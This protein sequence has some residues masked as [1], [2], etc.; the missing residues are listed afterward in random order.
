[1]NSPGPLAAPAAEALQISE[2]VSREWGCTSGSTRPC[3]SQIYNEGAARGE[4]RG[5][6]AF[7]LANEMDALGIEFERQIVLLAR[8]NLR[9]TPPLTTAELRHA[10]KQASKSKY[11][12]YACG[13][14]YLSAYCIGEE[15]PHCKSINRWSKSPLSISNIIFSDWLPH[16]TAVQLKTFLGLYRWSRIIGRGPRHTV[17]FTFASIERVCGV[18]RK[19]IRKTLLAL[20]DYGLIQDVTFAKGKG[21]MSS[22]KF[23]TTLPT[24]PFRTPLGKNHVGKWANRGDANDS[25]DPRGGD[26]HDDQANSAG[27]HPD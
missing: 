12:P 2:Q 25:D 21:S 16:L 19:Y 1:M 13:N 22:F 23:P 15:C 6:Y 5:V 9:V 7:I 10:A 4:G 18:N 24:P 17:H 3:I 11:H 14:P 8:W 20:E 27:G 26:Q